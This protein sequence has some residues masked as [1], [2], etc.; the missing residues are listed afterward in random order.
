MRM[1]R[2]LKDGLGR[3]G[4]P[5]KG[6]GMANCHMVG[7]VTRRNT[8]SSLID[9]RRL[10]RAWNRCE[11]LGVEGN[12]WMNMESMREAGP[13]ELPPSFLYSWSPHWEGLIGVLDLWVWLCRRCRLVQRAENGQMGPWGG[14]TGA[15][16]SS[17]KMWPAITMTETF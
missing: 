3:G 13:Q 2:N 9:G 10:G 8:E 14:A 17:R 15:V 5:L 1:S 11:G 7:S 12:A 16:I 6:S 4:G